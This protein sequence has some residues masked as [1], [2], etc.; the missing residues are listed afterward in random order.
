[1]FAAARRRGFTLL[2]LLLALTVAATI[3]ASLATTLYT[4]FRARTSAERAI[5]STRS[6][7]AI[8]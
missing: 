4:A 2:E 3:T 5:E 8:G 6:L 7:E 1:M